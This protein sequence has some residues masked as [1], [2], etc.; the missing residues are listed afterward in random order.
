MRR[1]HTIRLKLIRAGVGGAAFVLAACSGDGPSDPGSLPAQYGSLS[2][3]ISGLP[4]AAQAGV[5]VT[6]P[7]GFTRAVSSTTTL[8]Q[9]SAGTYTVA[10]ADVTHEGAIYTGAPSTQTF[11]VAA[12]ASVTTPDVI[13]SLATGALSVTLAGLPQSSTASIVISGPEGYTR[14]LE[15]ATDI[16]GLKP[17]TYSIEA[18]E[19]QLT[20]GRY[21]ATP[22]AQQVEVAA[23]LTPSVA[24][25]V[26]AL[27]TGSLALNI[28]GLP[29]GTA[30][31]VT[32][33]GPGAYSQSVTQ[34]T[35]LENL[36]PGTYTIA[37]T[38]VLSGS[39]FMPA[40]TLQQ[41]PV[42]ASD[43]PAQASVIYVSAGTSLSIQITGLPGHV[44][45]SM[46]LTGPN[47]YSKQLTASQVLTGIAAGSYTLTAAPVTESCAS[48]APAP[49]TQTVTVAAGQ[50]STANVAYSTGSGP[51][52]LCIDGVYI[53]QAV[54][55]YDNSV[56]LVAGRNGLLRVFVRASGAN[57]AQ[58]AVRARFYNSTGTLVNTVMMQAPSA[59]VPVTIDEASIGSSWNA[60]LT[61]AFLQPG[62]RMLVDV[63]PNNALA[64][65]NESDNG[66]PADGTPAT[67]DVRTVS[68]IFLSIIPVV[69]AS[70][71]DTGRVDASNKANFILPM[72]RMFPVASIDAEVRAPYTYTGP[73]LQSGGGNW[74]T[75][76]SE[77]NA[78]R[79][80]ESTGR[81]YYG[82]VRVGYNSG[83][84][85]VGYIGLPAAIGWDFQ[86]SGTEV[87][88]HELG[89]NFGRLHAP[90]GNPQGVDNQYPY[91]DASIGAF[92]Y[93]ILSGVVKFP[94]LR[95]LMSYCNPPWISDYTYSGILSFRASVYP[96]LG[97]A[98]RSKATTQRG[99]LVWGRIEQGQFVL[100][101]A[102]EVDAPVLLPSRTGPH[103]LEGFG[104]SGEILFS[105]AFSGERVAD[106]RNPD[107]QTFAFVVPLSQ[108]RGVGLNRLRL[109][110]LG[111]QVE[112]RSLGG[113]PVPT[114]HRTAPGRVRVSWNANA[115]RV[116]M[117]RDARSGQILSFSRGGAVDLRTASD[118]L[119][120]TLSDGVRSVRTR[121]RPQ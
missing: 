13:Y 84:A 92:G 41:V 54:Q 17:G 101:P 87:M 73:E 67:L 82:V 47:G 12:G 89:H 77:I 71:G 59:S 102:I 116:A 66:Y 28:S 69:Q 114:A 91:S 105:F 43:Q 90:C 7:G 60:T 23:S 40:P 98:V 16:P 20:N 11:T 32:V 94:V 121:V 30:A 48:Y 62:L 31:A 112:Q 76:L 118:D 19:V 5:T 27:S 44:P 24:H 80:A 15:A 22:G 33:T 104:P 95:D 21:A 113:T 110:A 34:E 83:V 100:E 10:A 2:V 109:S 70:R 58:P 57:A 63:D 8:T 86:P 39:L 119:E 93:D 1:L 79:V 72:E 97:S 18:R 106:S 3:T 14:A 99:L 9:L 75:L 85:G 120:I 78:L 37:A 88:A 52:N 56:P 74:I 55:A 46:T 26:Y 65:P 4:D 25:V 81:M 6:G 42:V 107:D 111:R 53:T 38:H 50:G 68:P 64:E 103:R 61:G 29:P 108:L 45:A 51:A 35:V 117:I 49:V 115:A 96:S 36:A